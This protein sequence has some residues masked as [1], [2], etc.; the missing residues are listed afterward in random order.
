[1]KTLAHELMKEKLLQFFQLI[2]LA[3]PVIVSA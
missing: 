1:M 3:Y 2:Y